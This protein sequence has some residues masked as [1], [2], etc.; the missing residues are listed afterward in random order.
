VD[1]L[2][3]VLVAAW[4]GVRTHHLAGRAERNKNPR[5][6]QPTSACPTARLRISEFEEVKAKTLIIIIIIIIKGPM[7]TP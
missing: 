4:L 2:W 6:G 5:P 1:R 3:I 7:F